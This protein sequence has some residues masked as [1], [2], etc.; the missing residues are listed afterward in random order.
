MII[1]FKFKFF[2]TC[3][4]IDILILLKIINA[5]IL[6]I[7]SYLIIFKTE[8]CYFFCEWFQLPI[9]VGYFKNCLHSTITT[10]YQKCLFS[11]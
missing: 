9:I 8:N 5:V 11:I 10:K 3:Y 7:L 4:I 2:L 1:F 6:S